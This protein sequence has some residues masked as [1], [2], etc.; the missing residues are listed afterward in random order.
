MNDEARSNDA[1]E[2]FVS[3]GEFVDRYYR[4][5]R[6]RGDGKRERIINDRI[7]DLRAFGEARISRHD[8]VTGGAVVLYD[9]TCR[10]VQYLRWL[11]TTDGETIYDP[12]PTP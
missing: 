2:G 11:A 5:D 4:R 10:P 3:A 1:D 6:L 9:P 7:K 8:S 12:N